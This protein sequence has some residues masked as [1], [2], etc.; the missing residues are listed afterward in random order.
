MHF[1]GYINEYNII[2]ITIAL[3]PIYHHVLRPWATLYQI[4]LKICMF[5]ITV[6]FLIYEIN[7]LSIN[8]SDTIGILYYHNPYIQFR[9][10]VFLDKCFN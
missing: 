1:E 10:V 6:L 2:N 5:K 8:S 7:I 4:R 9:I 3:K